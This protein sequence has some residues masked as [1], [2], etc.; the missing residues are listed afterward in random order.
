MCL[1]FWK[2]CILIAKQSWKV[3]IFLALHSEWVVVFRGGFHGGRD[4]W[5]AVRTVSRLYNEQW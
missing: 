4:G 5:E 3:I 1:L 2:N